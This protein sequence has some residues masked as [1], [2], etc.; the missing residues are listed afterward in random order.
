MSSIRK[1]LAQWLPL[2][3]TAAHIF[4]SIY[5]IIWVGWLLAIPVIIISSFPVALFH[6]WYMPH[7]L[8]AVRVMGDQ[9]NMML[10]LKGKP[11]PFAIKIIK[12]VEKFEKRALAAEEKRDGTRTELSAED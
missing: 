2:V 9:I 3:V 8:G 12:I 4:G 11:N 7:I 1:T 6:L 5:L 10:M